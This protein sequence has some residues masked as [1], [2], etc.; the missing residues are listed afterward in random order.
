[1]LKCY[2][3]CGPWF[4][5]QS[6]YIPSREPVSISIRVHRIW[7]GLYPNLRVSMWV[8]PIG[9]CHFSDHGDWFGNGD[10]TSSELLIFQETLLWFRALRWVFFSTIFEVQKMLH[11]RMWEQ[12][13]PT[14]TQKWRSVMAT[15][16]TRRRAES[17]GS[18][19]LGP[20]TLFE[21]LIKQ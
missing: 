5:P 10:H 12:R 11:Q 16:Q 21:S 15:Y 13:Q 8:K 9:T 18:E 4:F 6:M 19:Y 3:F 1:M 2:V 14:Y 20:V 7:I 17:R